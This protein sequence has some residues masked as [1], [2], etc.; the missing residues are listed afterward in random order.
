LNFLLLL[1]AYLPSYHHLLVCSTETQQPDL[2]FPSAGAGK[3]VKRT[4]EK[5]QKIHPLFKDYF[6]SFKTSD[7]TFTASKDCVVT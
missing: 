1:L 5:E 3:G 6:G 2:L 4:W 7:M